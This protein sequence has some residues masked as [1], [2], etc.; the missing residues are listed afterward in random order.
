MRG[1]HHRTYNIACI[2]ALG[3]K[4]GEAVKWLRETAAT[5]FPSYPTFERDHYLDPI[6][7]STEFTQFMAEMKSQNERVRREFGD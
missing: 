2:Y 3:G 5:G 7:E 6:R 4:S 1:Y